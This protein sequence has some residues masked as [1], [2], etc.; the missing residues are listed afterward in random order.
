MFQHKV[1]R[2]DAALRTSA[3]MRWRTVVA[4]L[5]LFRIKYKILFDID[6][7]AQELMS[8]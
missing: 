6:L 1:T 8:R 4:H 3:N 7:A 5:Q 2:Q